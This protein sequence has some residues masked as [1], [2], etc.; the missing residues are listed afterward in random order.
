MLTS[1]ILI[2]AA[3]ILSAGLLKVGREKKRRTGRKCEKER[4]EEHTQNFR[5]LVLYIAHRAHHRTTQ[6]VKHVA[7]LYVACAGSREA[8]CAATA[9][10]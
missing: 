3:Y 1:D 10:Q 9:G 6:L 2:S 8:H 5:C 7:L 4:K